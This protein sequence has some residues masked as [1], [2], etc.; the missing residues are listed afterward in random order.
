MWAWKANSFTKIIW[1]A[2][3]KIPA[4]NFSLLGFSMSYFLSITWTLDRLLKMYHTNKIFAF[5]FV[6]PPIPS[7][8][9]FSLTSNIWFLWKQWKS[10]MFRKYG[11]FKLSIINALC[12]KG[13]NISSVIMEL[14]AL[15]CVQGFLSAKIWQ[16]DTGLEAYS[17]DNV[18]DFNQ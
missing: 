11:W 12:N 15:F 3:L 2:V 13:C 16:P 6:S 17:T 14:S 8:L 4:K 9:R 18:R 5:W 10:E 1:T 7:P